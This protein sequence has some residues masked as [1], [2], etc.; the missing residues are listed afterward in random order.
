MKF[1][2]CDFDLRS[3]T[4]TLFEKKIAQ[5]SIFYI[6]EKKFDVT[7]LHSILHIHTKFGYSAIILPV[8]CRVYKI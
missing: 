2:L 1:Q 3:Q 4:N 6:F 7:H 5:K 8:K